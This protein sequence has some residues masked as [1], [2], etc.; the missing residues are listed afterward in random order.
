MLKVK[1]KQWRLEHRIKTI[2]NIR[3]EDTISLK[4]W[5]HN[6]NLIL[7]PGFVTEKAVSC[8]YGSDDP[9]SVLTLGG[10]NPEYYTGDFTFV[11]LSK[12]DRWR[13]KLDEVQ[14]SNIYRL[15]YPHGSQAVVDTSAPLIAGPIDAVASLNK[16]IGAKPLKDNPMLYTLDHSQ[17]DSLPD[18]EF[19]VNGQ[20]LSLTSEDYVVKIPGKRKGDRYFSGIMGKKRKK[21][22][23]PGWTL[24]LN[25]MRT[26]Y[27]QFDKGNHRIGFAKASSFANKYLQYHSDFRGVIDSYKM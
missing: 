16:V 27:T 7:V 3:V 25:F 23:K 9:D 20:K 24:G 6:R 5:R 11:N 19:I 14:L 17:L 1:R 10:T 26:Y 15:V 2:L 22:K 21:S 4:L 8:R 18:L 13:F 12:P